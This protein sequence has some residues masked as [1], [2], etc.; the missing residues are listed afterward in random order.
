MIDRS[1]KIFKYLLI[2][3]L[4]VH[5]QLMYATIYGQGLTKLAEKLGVGSEEVA[6]DFLKEFHDAFPNLKSFVEQSKEFARKNGYVETLFGRRRYLPNINSSDKEQSASDER[7]AVN[8]RIQGSASDL[9]KLTMLKLDQ[10]LDKTKVDAEILLQIHDELVFQVR[11]DE[12][13]LNDFTRLLVREMN[14]CGSVIDTKLPIRV[15]KG[16]NWS[17]MSEFDTKR[18]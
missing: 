12:Q 5:T 18:I 1:L 9:V 16:P 14:S 8:S 13:N 3:F 4:F 6:R 10:A 7:K 15:K 2:I 11:N 17:D